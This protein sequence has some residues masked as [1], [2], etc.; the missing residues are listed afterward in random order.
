MGDH[1]TYLRIY[2]QFCAV[3]R[4]LGLGSGRDIDEREQVRWCRENFLNFRSLKAAV[5]IREQLWDEFCRPCEGTQE[6]EVIDMTIDMTI[7]IPNLPPILLLIA[8]VPLLLV[9]RGMERTSD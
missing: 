1:H 5:R 3:G 8:V 9:F 4:G 7:D 6:I 2:D